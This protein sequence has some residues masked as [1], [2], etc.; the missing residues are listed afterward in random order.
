MIVDYDNIGS[1]WI[2]GIK[3]WKSKTNFGE[4]LTRPRLLLMLV[5]S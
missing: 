4:F 3:F 5:L 2:P 1:H